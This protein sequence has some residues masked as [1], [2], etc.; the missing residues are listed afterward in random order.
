M[1]KTRFKGNYI[2]GKKV[3]E[4]EITQEDCDE[5]NK[6]NNKLFG[7]LDDETKKAMGVIESKPHKIEFLFG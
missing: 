1:S 2:N 7:D 6:L 3:M 5:M 4:L